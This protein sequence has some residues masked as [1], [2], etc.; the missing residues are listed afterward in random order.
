M[1]LALRPRNISGFA[2]HIY[3]TL[4]SSTL[5]LSGLTNMLATDSFTPAVQAQSITSAGHI[6]LANGMRLSGPCIFLGGKV[7]LWDV[8]RLNQG[9]WDGWEKER[10]EMFDV[11]VPKPGISLCYIAF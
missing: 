3:R 6:E 7:F 11:V 4:H 9:L 2:T 1:P 10:F 5:R 8:P